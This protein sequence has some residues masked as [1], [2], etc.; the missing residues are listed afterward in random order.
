MLVCKLP[1]GSP[2]IFFTCQGEGI[3][4]GEPCVFVRFSSCCLSC[5]FCDSFFTWNFEGRVKTPHKYS[6]PVKR[7]EYVIELT[8]EEVAKI[9]IDKA[10]LT[11]RIVFTGG[12][13]L[14][15]QEAIAEILE[16]LWREDSWYIEVETS[17]TIPL[18]QDLKL[19]QINCSPKLE[20]SGNSKEARDKPV[21]IKQFLDLAGQEASTWKPKLIFKFVIGKDTFDADMKEVQEWQYKYNVPNSMVYLMP[22]GI[23]EEAI[24][25]GTIFLL[26]KCMETGY[27]LSTRLHVLLYGNKRGT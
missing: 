10:G 13:P 9:I 16:I 4:M 23:T 26:E 27:K 17:G 8:A 21:V 6:K 14:L 19:N 22:E 1:D 5:V 2:E 11:R 24:K 18:A 7:D 3:S 20:S 12:E 15:Q 25:E